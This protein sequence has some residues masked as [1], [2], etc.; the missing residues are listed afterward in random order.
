MANNKRALDLLEDVGG[1]RVTA[2]SS[3]EYREDGSHRIGLPQNPTKMD[4]DVAATMLTQQAAAERE[5]YEYT[6]VFQARPMD[7][8]FSFNQVVKDVFGMTPIGKAVHS[9]FG[10]QPPEIKTV[11]ISPT[12]TAQVPW[13]RLEFSPLQAIFQ[14]GNAV[15][16]DYGLAFAV[17]VWA[18]KNKRVA[19]DGLFA[20]IEAR[21]SAN[22]IYRNKAIIGAGQLTREGNYREPSFF[23]PYEVKREQVVYSKDVYEALYHSVWGRIVNADAL[24]Q[25]HVGLGN[26]VLLHGENGTGKTLAAAVTAQ[27]ALEN[28]WSMIQA[29]WDEDLKQVVKFASNIGVP[30][31]VVIEDIEKLIQRDV[32]EMD[33]LLD[34]FDG[35][36]AKNREVMLLMTSN[37][38][39][40]LTKSMTRAGR[41]DRMIYV[42]GLDK[43][44]V[45]R[46]IN[47]LIPASQREQLDY[48]ALHTAYDGYTPS[49]IVEALKNVKV[50]SIIRT[51]RVGQ[52]LATEDFVIEAEALRPAWN[53]HT[54]ATDRPAVDVM[55]SVLEQIVESA[56]AAQLEVHAL[57]N[58]N[59]GESEFVLR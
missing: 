57:S 53:R 12:E 26:K 45:E 47:A 46:L 33:A 38:V 56:V 59:I 51:G 25:A 40:E 13:G 22:S 1:G 50:A 27:Y 4:L 58:D 43:E 55:G 39:H 41:I 19:I 48:E 14:L 20:M 8:A 36:G 54:E 16:E 28:G 34:L 24:R 17:T 49:W 15:D 9:F 3:F 32:K 10:T 5:T 2:E 52:P 7:G 30:T 6:K 18:P 37:H 31:V 42:S 21:L 11:Q 29:R 35:I 44:G 23:N